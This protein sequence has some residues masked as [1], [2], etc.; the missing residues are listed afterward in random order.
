VDDLS[1]LARDFTNYFSL[2]LVDAPCSGLGTIRRN[3]GMK[4]TVSEAMVK[5]LSAKQTR[6]LETSA[7]LV[8]QGGRLVYA[9]CTLLR[10]ENEEVV[11]RFLSEHP[12][13]TLLD[14]A[15]QAAKLHVPD[16]ASDRF[17]KLLPHRHGTDGFFCAMLQKVS[18]K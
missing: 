9:T 3:P 6:L 18:S 11:Q 13:F 5:E 16:A 14:A 10:E 15:A 2:V 4:W 17:I 1:E 8:K 7:P 12:E